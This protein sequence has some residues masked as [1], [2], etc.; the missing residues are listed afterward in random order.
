MINWTKK[1][2]LKK[3]KKITRAHTSNKL[4]AHLK[5]CSPRPTL[6]TLDN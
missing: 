6:L 4:L 1:L 3:K 5:E 2:E